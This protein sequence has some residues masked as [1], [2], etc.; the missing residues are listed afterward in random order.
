MSIKIE[1]DSEM[2]CGQK[3]L[4]RRCGPWRC[5]TF[6][7]EEMGTIFGVG[8]SGEEGAVLGYGAASPT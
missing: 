6:G 8:R 5:I 1:R 3:G 4:H 2:K 7:C